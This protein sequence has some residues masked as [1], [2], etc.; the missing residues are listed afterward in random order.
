MTDDLGVPLKY[1][2]EAVVISYQKGFEDAIECLKNSQKLI[3]AE[4]MK[5][6]IL[7][8]VQKHGKVRAQW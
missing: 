1:F 6:K 3:D 4:Q 7:E 2:A 8:D 5:A